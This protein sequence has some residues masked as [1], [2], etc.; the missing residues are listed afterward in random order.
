M[1]KKKKKRTPPSPTAHCTVLVACK[2]KHSKCPPRASCHLHPVPQ[3]KMPVAERKSGQEEGGLLKFRNQKKLFLMYNW[4]SE[5]KSEKSKWCSYV[6]THHQ[7]YVYERR[8]RELLLLSELLQ[9]VQNSPQ[10]M[11]E[12]PSSSKHMWG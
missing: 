2:I 6:P 7:K 3:G 1:K 4:D 9:E 10:R 11:K 12:G 5:W 8:V